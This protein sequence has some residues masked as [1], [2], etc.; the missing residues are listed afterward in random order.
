MNE[1]RPTARRERYHEKAASASSEE[2]CRTIL[3][4]VAA[5]PRG[6]VTTYGQLARRAGLPGRAR[7]V[8]R[9]LSQT[10]AARLVPWHRVVNS[11][12]RLSLPKGSKAYSEQRSRLCAEGV[13]FCKERVSLKLFGWG[14]VDHSPLLD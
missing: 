7:L 14:L 10:P 3:E 1:Q 12:G 4:A 11:Q 2:A 13:E 9:V 6:R 8:G 5:I